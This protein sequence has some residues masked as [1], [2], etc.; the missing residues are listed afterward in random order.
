MI[1]FEEAYQRVFEVFGVRT[2]TELAEKLEIRQ[3]SISDAK[4]RKS[5]PDGWLI[6]AI[7]EE[8]VHPR[9]IMTGQGGKYAVASDQSEKVVYNSELERIRKDA[10]NTAYEEII[11]TLSVEKLLEMV[12]MA[13]PKSAVVTIEI[14]SKKK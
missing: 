13:L 11:Q 10:H 4:K 14:P 12:S 7:V 2:Q 3:S 6:K 1:N 5:I 8:G 9:W